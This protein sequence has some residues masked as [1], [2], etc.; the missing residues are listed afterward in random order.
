MQQKMLVTRQLTLLPSTLFTRWR[1]RAK[2]GPPVTSCDPAA[3]APS[4]H[5]HQ[6]Y[7]LYQT[8]SEQ[9]IAPQSPVL[10]ALSQKVD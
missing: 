2:V 9:G 4:L 8:T 5:S 10:C 6:G 7:A 3:T 1:G